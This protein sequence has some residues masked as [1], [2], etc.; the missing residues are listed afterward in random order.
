MTDTSA[1]QPGRRV[2]F[3]GWWVEST[4]GPQAIDVRVQQEEQWI[5]GCRWDIGD[6]ST[7]TDVGG[8]VRIALQV[9]K[10]FVAF[11]RAAESEGWSKCR[12][13]RDP[14]PGEESERQQDDTDSACFEDAM[15]STSLTS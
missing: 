10:W 1:V 3:N 11:R 15:R 8:A 4:L 14:L 2:S 6:R 9:S 7:E 12:I 13:L 5:L